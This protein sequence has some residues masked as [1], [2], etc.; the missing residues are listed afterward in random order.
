MTD[1]PLCAEH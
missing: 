1:R